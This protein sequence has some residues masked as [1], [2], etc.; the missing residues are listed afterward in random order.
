[1]GANIMIN[2]E[3]TNLKKNLTKLLKNF[4]ITHPQPLSMNKEGTKG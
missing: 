4:V 2:N 3:T 1:M